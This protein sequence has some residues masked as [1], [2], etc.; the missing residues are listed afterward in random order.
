MLLDTYDIYFGNLFCFAHRCLWENYRSGKILK[1]R[2]PQTHWASLRFFSKNIFLRKIL[3]HIDWLSFK[4]K[5]WYLELCLLK[6]SLINQCFSLSHKCIWACVT[7]DC[8]VCVSGRYYLSYVLSVGSKWFKM[9]TLT[10]LSEN[11][12]SFTEKW[13][14][15]S[16]T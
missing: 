6:C 2:M 11:L 7:S 12:S 8:C 9:P 10:A 4:H 14:Y 3:L 16:I 13:K 1:Q 15:S 5:I